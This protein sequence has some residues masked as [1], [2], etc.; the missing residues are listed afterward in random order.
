MRFPEL[1]GRPVEVRYLRAPRDRRGPVDGGAMLRERRIV[2]DAALR[3]DSGRI[4]VHEIFH[5][6]WVRL[7]NPRRRTFEDLLRRELQARARGE[8]GWSAEWRKAELSAADA[9]ARTRRWREYCCESFCDTAAWMF[10][11]VRRHPHFTLAPRFRRVR[12]AWFEAQG[13]T[14]AIS[15]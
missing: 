12:R 8:L 1:S 2:L 5:F 15:I 3:R 7:G 6:A 4:L 9:A 11:G 10:S 13:L 14:R